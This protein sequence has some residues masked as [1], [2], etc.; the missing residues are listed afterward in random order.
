MLRP[1]ISNPRFSV[2]E[3]ERYSPCAAALFAW[4]KKVILRHL[5]G[6]GKRLEDPSKSFV[7][8]L[9]ARSGANRGRKQRPTDSK[10]KSVQDGPR[11]RIL[12][13]RKGLGA[14]NPSDGS[15]EDYLA[16]GINSGTAV[17]FLDDPEFLDAFADVEDEEH[18]QQK[19]HTLIK[20]KMTESVSI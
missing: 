6:V 9:H 4:V 20:K 1:V 11:E 18:V 3:I 13:P 2:M 12:R 15:F 7:L 8:S 10:T 19:R 5:V 14:F 17:S 16:S